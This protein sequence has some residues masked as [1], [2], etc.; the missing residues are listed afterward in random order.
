[1]AGQN[2]N[3]ERA[4]A[5]IAECDYMPQAD[6]AEKY[7]VSARTIRRWKSRVDEDPEL[8][9]LV[10]QKKEEFVERWADKLGDTLRE[11]IDY[12]QEAARNADAEKP[13]PQM[14]RAINGT[15]KILSEIQLTKDILDAR[16]P[17]SSAP[18]AQSGGALSPPQ[19]N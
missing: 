12:L 14:V 16:N 4:A 15:V 17:G 8:S 2:F 19:R 1:M 13:D 6:V 3:Y 5:A 10:R 7:D 11:G 18:D 9:A